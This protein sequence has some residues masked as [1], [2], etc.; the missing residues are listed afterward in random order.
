[1]KYGLAVLMLLAF[2]T[3]FRG[4]L[5]EDQ[6]VSKNLILFW[7]LLSKE[8]EKRSTNNDLYLWNIHFIGLPN[9]WKWD[10]KFKKE[11]N[12]DSLSSIISNGTQEF[13]KKKKEFNLY[14]NFDL[15]FN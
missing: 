6:E 8:I 5:N 4:P 13:D 11:L 12:F 9:W 2:G 10:R 15:I 7:I 1:M 14:L 3:F